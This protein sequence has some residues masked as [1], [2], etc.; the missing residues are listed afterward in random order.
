MADSTRLCLSC[1]DGALASEVVGGGADAGLI[2]AGALINPRRDHPV[3]VAYPL[4]GRL[5]GRTRREFVPIA[6]LQSEGAVRLIDGRVECI[7]C[8]DP[9]NALGYD[10]MLVKPNRRSALCL[11]C[12]K[13]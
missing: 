4:T 7:S 13:K 6:R 10:K 8:H 11:S 2:A 9:H 1:H 5:S 12:H 3:G